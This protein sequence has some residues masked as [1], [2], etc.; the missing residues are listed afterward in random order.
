M[1]GR[2]APSKKAPPGEAALREAA[3]AAL[4]ARALSEAGLAAVLR[5]RVAAWAR[6]AARAGED[7]EAVAAAVARAE[8]AAVG[9]VARLREVGLIDDAAYAE[10]RAAGLSRAGKSRRAV[11]RDLADKGIAPALAERASASDRA[12]ELAAA[13]TLARKRRLG[14]FA[15]EEPE[16]ALARAKAKQRALGAF[17]RAGF[18]FDV[19]KEAL[20]TP[21]ED[22]EAILQARA[23]RGL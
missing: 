14:P 8:E 20:G 2:R 4:A 15:R 7:G 5:R 19:A 17:A 23:P 12:T 18:S 3:L 13:L 9:I 16:D 21:R 11:A 1:T 22:A 10:R 6:G